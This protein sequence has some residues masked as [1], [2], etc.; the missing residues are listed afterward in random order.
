MIKEKGIIVSK[1]DDKINA[2]VILRE[3]DHFD[4]T[5]MITLVYGNG[6]GIKNVLKYIQNFAKEKK[7]ERIQV[8]SKLKKL[9]QVTDFEKKFSFYLLKKKL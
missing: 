1:K 2:V 8:L 7:Y 6:I 5:L 9:P 4:K 3:S